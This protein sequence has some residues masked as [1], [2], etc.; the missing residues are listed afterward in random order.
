MQCDAVL[1]HAVRL[2]QCT[3][4]YLPALP[5]SCLQF[6]P[7]TE[8]VI[9]DRALSH[10]TVES[11]VDKNYA[12]TDQYPLFGSCDPFDHGFDIDS[13]IVSYKTGVPGA[14]TMMIII[15]I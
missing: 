10:C 13:R 2:L 9:F 5:G 4:T 12:I 14:K 15:M 7:L 8:D 11:V 1:C 3:H 6:L